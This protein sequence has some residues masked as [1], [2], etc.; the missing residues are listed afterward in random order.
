[1]INA[2]I[3]RLLNAVEQRNTELLAHYENEIRLATRSK[4]SILNRMRNEDGPT[5]Y[6]VQ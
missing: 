1:M 4:T 5:L 2:F 6:L 3:S